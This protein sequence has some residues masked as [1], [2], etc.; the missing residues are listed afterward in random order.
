[1]GP[2]SH[3]TAPRNVP[4]LMRGKRDPGVADSS[5]AICVID[6]DASVRRGLTRLIQS[7]RRD[8]V[9][10]ESGEEFLDTCGHLP[11]ALVILDLRLPGRSGIETLRE[12]RAR[13][14]DAAAVMMTGH[15]RD[16]VRRECLE[17]GA[18]DLWAKPVEPTALDGLLARI[19]RPL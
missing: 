15:E 12:M 1:M 17:A 3:W 4:I 2:G 11:F 7:M 13:G 8:C 18:L 16:G 6:D 5:G 14:N 9:T 19:A 10:C